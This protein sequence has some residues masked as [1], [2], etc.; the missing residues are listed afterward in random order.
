MHTHQITDSSILVGDTE[1]PQHEYR[2]PRRRLKGMADLQ[3][4]L[5][6]VLGTPVPVDMPLER[7]VHRTLEEAVLDSGRAFMGAEL[8]R[9][10]PL[11][12]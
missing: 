9:D 2:P 5:T 3:A 12:W 4:G 8:L 6:H 11:V 10:K 1:V 7:T